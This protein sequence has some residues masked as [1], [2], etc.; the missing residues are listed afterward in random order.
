MDIFN[1]KINLGL[2]LDLDIKA[3]NETNANDRLRVYNLKVAN[4]FVYIIFRN[5]ILENANYLLLWIFSIFQRV[6]L[7]VL[8]IY[9]YIIV[10]VL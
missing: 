4:K 6:V 7:I 1:G 10:N 5:Y 3:Q 9:K 2:K 8:I